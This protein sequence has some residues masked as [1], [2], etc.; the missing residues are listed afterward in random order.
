MIWSEVKKVMVVYKGIVLII[1]G[2]IVTCLMWNISK[3]S[4]SK[5]IAIFG[6]YEGKFNEDDVIKLNERYLEYSQDDFFDVMQKYY[7]GEIDTEEYFEEI[8][9]GNDNSYMAAI[10]G[11]IIELA[12]YARINPDKRY[13]VYQDGWRSLL[14][15]EK[16]WI[17]SI[18]LLFF[19]LILF[20]GDT[21]NSV[22][23]IINVTARGGRR[24]LAY[25]MLT[26]VILVC[27]VVGTNQLA[28]FIICYK[29]SGLSGFGFP[30]QSLI[31]FGDSSVNCSLIQAYIIKSILMIVTYIFVGSVVAASVSLFG[32]K[33]LTICIGGVLFFAFYILQNDVLNSFIPFVGFD[34]TNSLLYNSVL[35]G[36][37]LC[38]IFSVCFFMVAIYFKK[39]RRVT[40]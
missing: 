33:Y 6:Q 8:A 17:P 23:T 40:S 14:T 21:Q 2:V 30:V 26:Y 12:E 32:N 27:L 36:V 1:L 37:V 16:V 4:D 28:N 29:K 10:Y 22:E 35:K 3:S 11:Q 9:K 7:N 5:K 18:L 24:V 34:S 39:T 38:V 31:Y 15:S 20:C 13:I 19:A 25:R